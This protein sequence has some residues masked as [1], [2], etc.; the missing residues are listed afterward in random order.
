MHRVKLIRIPRPTIIPRMTEPIDYQQ[1]TTMLPF[2]N[3]SGSLIASG[4]L[5]L[6][7]GIMTGC[8]VLLAPLFA[9]SKPETVPETP[10]LQPASETPAAAAPAAPGVESGH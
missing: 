1:P 8:G 6:L 7:A 2:A 9:C 5:M 3:R 4:I 10:P